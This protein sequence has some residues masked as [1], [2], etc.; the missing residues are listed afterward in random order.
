MTV[1]AIASR[2]V[3][4]AIGEHHEVTP[5]V[6]P[7]H[8]VRGCEPLKFFRV[9]HNVGYVAVGQHPPAAGEDGALAANDSPAAQVLV[10]GSRIAGTHPGEP[11][12]HILLE[13]IG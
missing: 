3:P 4:F 5:I 10:D 1:A 9:P 11:P 8:S 13:F 2:P 6:N 12:R 7:G